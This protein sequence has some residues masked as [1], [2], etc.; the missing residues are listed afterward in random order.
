MNHSPVPKT[1]L[2]V[3]WQ[4][5][6]FDECGTGFNCKF[7][8]RRHIETTH[9]KLK[10]YQCT[11]CGKGFASK[12]N[13]TEHTLTH[14]GE[15]PFECPVCRRSFRQASQFSLHKRQ[16]R[17]DPEAKLLKSTKRSRALKK[18]SLPEARSL[19]LPQITLEAK[20]PVVLPSLFS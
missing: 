19:L 11:L 20:F 14:T 1:Y 2:E 13:L 16:H 9:L 8:L 18:S 5:C 15:K 17:D 10:R 6:M 4:C 12:Q 3:T 7:N